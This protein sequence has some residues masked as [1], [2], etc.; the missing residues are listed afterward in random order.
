MSTGDE[1]NATT[2]NPAGQQNTANTITCTALRTSHCF[3]KFDPK[4]QNKISDVG[5]RGK[6]ARKAF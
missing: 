5:Y 3:K 4:R 1:V 6:K 2:H